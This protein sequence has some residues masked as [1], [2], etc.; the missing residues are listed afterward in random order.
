[1]PP[2]AMVR[3]VGIATAVGTVYLV[4]ASLIWENLRFPYG[5]VSLGAILIF[6]WAGYQ[7][8]LG[9]PW[10]SGVAAALAALLSAI[11]S[12]LLL[13]VLAPNRPRARPE[14]IAEVLTLITAAGLVLGWVGATLR[15][16]LRR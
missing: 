3:A 16:S 12:W 13:G 7:F 6:I 9:K 15:R 14:A 10:K 1:M 2:R 11:I 5:S 8:N 4:V